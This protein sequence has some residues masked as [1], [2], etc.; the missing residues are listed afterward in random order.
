MSQSESSSQSEKEEQINDEGSEGDE[1]EDNSENNEDSEN[2][3]NENNEE[4]MPQKGKRRRLKR[5]KVTRYFN[6][7][8]VKI[9]IKADKMIQ[10]VHKY[11]VA[12][13]KD[14]KTKVRWISEKTILEK[15]QDALERYNSRPKKIKKKKIRRIIHKQQ[16][17]VDEENETKNES[18][19]SEKQVLPIKPEEEQ[20]K[21]SDD[22]GKTSID[23]TQNSDTA[24]PKENRQIEEILGMKKREKS[25]FPDYVVRFTDSN[26]L[27]RVSWKKMHEQYKI[28]LLNYYEQ[29]ITA[30]S[31]LLIKKLPEGLQV[32]ENL[33]FL[34]KS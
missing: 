31:F 16:K 19:D 8:S 11:K 22:E 24:K 32:E 5:K 18:I 1:D 33:H 27:E 26:K 7:D 30:E 13:T 15:A 34:Q 28:N 3:D 14:D 10:D 17:S 4:V 12:F 9:E 23:Q 21:Q 25:N 20:S 2:N 29:N 6:D